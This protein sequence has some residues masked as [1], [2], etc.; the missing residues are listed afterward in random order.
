LKAALDASVLTELLAPDAGSD[1][2]ESPYRQK[3]RALGDLL[4]RQKATI[5]IPTPVIAEVLVAT[6]Q[7]GALRLEMLQKKLA[8][9]VVSFDQ[10]AAFETASM[11]RAARDAG[12]KRAGRGKDE[13]WQQV[14][15]DWQIIATSKVN[16]ADVVYTNDEKFHKFSNEQGMKSIY[17]D[18]YK[19]SDSDPQ[20]S[21]FQPL[22]PK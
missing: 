15:F 9:R 13:S 10:R 19:L 22:H 16:Q 21:L 17:L 11:M 1:T 2:K 12:D 3:V 14:K 20:L 4:A 5:I 8:F 7:D 6:G 18:E